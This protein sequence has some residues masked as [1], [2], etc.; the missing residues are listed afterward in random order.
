M[1]SKSDE[2]HLPPAM[3]VR[4]RPARAHGHGH[5]LARRIFADEGVSGSVTGRR[6]LDAALAA[7]RLA[8]PSLSG[9]WTGL[10]DPSRT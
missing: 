2:R 6:G 9:N 3:D 5:R 7:L 4:I 8:I 1:T 10:G